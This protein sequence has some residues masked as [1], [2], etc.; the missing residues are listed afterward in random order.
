MLCVEELALENISGQ[1]S[2]HLQLHVHDALSIVGEVGADDADDLRC[3]KAC[4]HRWT[5]QLVR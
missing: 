3:L 1:E 5:G 2:G 4:E